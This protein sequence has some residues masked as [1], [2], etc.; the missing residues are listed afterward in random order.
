MITKRAAPE[1]DEVYPVFEEVVDNQNALKTL[2]RGQ[3]SK[4]GP[5]CTR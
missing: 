5:H 2:W 4:E 3:A 1:L